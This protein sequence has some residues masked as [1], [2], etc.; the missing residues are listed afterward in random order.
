MTADFRFVNVTEFFDG[1]RRI[2]LANAHIHTGL[3]AVS[4]HL[5]VW[6]TLSLIFKKLTFY[7]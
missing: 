5:M 4:S 6:A 7:T 1:V 3:L 2:H